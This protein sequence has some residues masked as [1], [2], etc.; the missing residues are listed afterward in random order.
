V[1]S[2]SACGR[3]K[4]CTTEDILLRDSNPTKWVF[5]ASLSVL[6]AC[7]PTETLNPQ[8]VF[9]DRF[10]GYCGQSFAAHIVEDDQPSDAW[11]QPLVVHIRDC[12]TDTLRMPLHV[13]DDRSRT[14]VL[15]RTEKGLNFQHIHLH[16][17]GSADA[18]SPYGGHTAENGTE[19]LQSFPV[20]AASKTLFEQN[21]LAV[22][23]Q[24]TW[25]LGFPSAD[26]MSYEL[27]R[28]NRSFIVHVDLSQPI[29][30]PPPAWGY[31]PAAN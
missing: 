28:P 25:R 4:L 9:F 7:Q 21:G 16:E 2:T 13:G 31:L 26:T 27:T 30:E 5:I 15:Q 24:N 6:S 20:D 18:V 1:R 3:V 12:E 8:H 17:D 10:L 11:N 14:W 19:S 29:A 22:S 23:T